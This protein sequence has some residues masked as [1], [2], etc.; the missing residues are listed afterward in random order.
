MES[1]DMLEIRQE[2][3]GP[4]DMDPRTVLLLQLWH[5]PRQIAEGKLDLQDE[6]EWQ[7]RAIEEIFVIAG[8]AECPGVGGDLRCRLRLFYDSILGK[9]TSRGDA[10]CER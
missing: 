6:L 3:R 9:T 7:L 1:H 8:E 4:V 10:T 5:G 2:E